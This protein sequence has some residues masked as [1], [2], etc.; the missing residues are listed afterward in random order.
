[1]EGLRNRISDPPGLWK[2]R[3]NS[4]VYDYW[5]NPQV[6]GNGGGVVAER[7]GLHG[8]VASA[9]IMTPANRVVFV[10]G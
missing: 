6:A 9:P 2:E 3:F 7:S 4:D 8:Y 1:M 10:K 5:V